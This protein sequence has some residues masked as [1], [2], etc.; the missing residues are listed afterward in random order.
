MLN[1]EKI[2]QKRSS[3]TEIPYINSNLLITEPLISLSVFYAANIVIKDWL[4]IF[5]YLYLCCKYCDQR[6][7]NL[8]IAHYLALGINKNKEFQ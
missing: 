2:E 4:I 6:S 3:S 7:S 8:A 5:L 1:E